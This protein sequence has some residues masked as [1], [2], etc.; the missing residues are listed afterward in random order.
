MPIPKIPY[1]VD[2]VE[3][4]VEKNVRVFPSLH[5]RGM[6]EEVQSHIVDI[7]LNKTVPW[8]QVIIMESPGV[9]R[10]GT[11]KELK[12]EKGI[13]GYTTVG[14]FSFESKNIRCRADEAGEEREETLIHE[15][16]H[17]I[18][19]VLAERKTRRLDMMGNAK[20]WRE[21]VRKELLRANSSE[22]IWNMQKKLPGVPVDEHLSYG[23]AKKE[24]GEESVAQCY[25]YYSNLCGLYGGNELRAHNRLNIVY[26]VLWRGFRENFLE[27]ALECAGELYLKSHPE[28]RDWLVE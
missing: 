18:S 3:K 6:R 10:L 17:K 9:I 20:V 15:F 11:R 27:D 25:L 7:L 26:N 13:R 21:I 24:Y 16:G 12:I 1:S 14:D 22:G 8:A 5:N 4:Y 19:R 23:Y 28:Y 2:E